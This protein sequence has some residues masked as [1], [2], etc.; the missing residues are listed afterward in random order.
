MLAG[1]ARISLLETAKQ[2]PQHLLRNAASRIDHLE[3]KA[4]LVGEGSSI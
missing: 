4:G 1:G 3:T 2:S